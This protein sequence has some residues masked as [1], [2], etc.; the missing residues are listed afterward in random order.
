MRSLLSLMNEEYRDHVARLLAEHDRDEA[1]HLAVGGNWDPIGAVE[2]GV[3]R[4]TG[5]TPTSNVLDVGCGSG[6]LAVRLHEQ[7]RGRYLGV[8]IVQPLVDYASE[9][10][11]RFE[12]AQTDGL[13][14]P[15]DDAS[16]DIMCFFSVFT[17]LPFEVVY[18]LLQ[19]AARVLRPGGR[20]VASFL[21]F[22]IERHWQI[23]D[24][25]VE[26][27]TV[28]RHHNQFMHRE[29]LARLARRAGLVSL[30][31]VGG[32]EHVVPIDGEYRRDD[33]EHV[34]SPARLGQS[35]MILER[36]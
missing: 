7:H 26:T 9:I 30:S 28:A 22:G 27:I 35:W 8:D 11:P 36:R 21:E 4:M 13:T 23:F 14:L 20:A 10:A 15:A 17:H 33:G 19:E 34:V 5:M 1:M 32:D 29:D 12:F 25:C 31:V 3:L 24:A 6:R 18:L 2:E 16:F